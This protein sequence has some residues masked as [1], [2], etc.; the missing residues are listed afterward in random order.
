LK[1]SN[2]LILLIGIFLA[3][4]A[5]IGIVIIFSGGRGS[6]PTTPVAPTELPT[7]F[8]TRPITLGTAITADML[9]VENRPV[10][11]RDPSAFGDPGVLLGQIARKDIAED[12]LLTAAD[13]ATSNLLTTVDCPPGQDCIAVK[14]DQVSGVGT[15]IRTG[16]YVDVLV[17]F[18]M[19]VITVDPVTGVAVAG[20][21]EIAGQ[22]AKM[23]LQGIQVMGHIL[24]PPP[25][26]AEGVPPPQGTAL[27]DQ[28]EIVILSVTKQQ[29]EVIKFAQ[30]VGAGANGLGLIG[31]TPAISLALRSPRDFRDP[32]TQEPIIP[33]DVVTTGITLALLIEQYGVLVPDIVEANLGSPSPSPTP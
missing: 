7:V 32:D 22:S 33:E 15:I 23:L 2:R 21:P 19:N 17:A 29:A 25:A 5:F 18:T 11:T 4:V 9:R 10:T 6:T 3:I 1:R 31:P 12:K 27:N 8:A 16:D 30:T 26:T 13:F 28:S 24:P 14:V 20:A